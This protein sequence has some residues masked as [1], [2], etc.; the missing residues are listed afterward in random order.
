MAVGHSDHHREY[1][2]FFPPFLLNCKNCHSLPATLYS[3]QQS[4]LKRMHIRA[5]LPEL[6]GCRTA[7]DPH[8]V[9][10]TSSGHRAAQLQLLPSAAYSL[11]T[12]L[13]TMSQLFCFCLPYTPLITLLLHQAGSSAG[14]NPEKF[15]SKGSIY[16]G[17][18]YRKRKSNFIFCVAHSFINAIYF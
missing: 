16:C 2:I 12:L 14:V 11:W 17:G 4:W 10:C 1:K 7:A 9:C 3:I 18:N 8:S 13:T 6:L 15:Y 5:G